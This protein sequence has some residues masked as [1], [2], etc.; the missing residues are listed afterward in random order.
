MLI[1]EFWF[2]WMAACW[3]CHIRIG[4]VT[5]F[6]SDRLGRQREK[7]HPENAIFSMKSL[8]DLRL[9]GLTNLEARTNP[10]RQWVNCSRR[11]R[12]EIVVRDIGEDG[13]IF[14]SNKNRRQCN[15]KIQHNYI[16][17]T[18]FFIVFKNKILKTT[19]NYFL[20]SVFKIH[21]LFYSF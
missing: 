7:K 19:L 10:K 5:F 2:Q 20:F 16:D 4:F 3:S 17:A 18:V 8:G 13:G 21:S 6:F 11:R 9:L 1:I 15:I 12:S 14:R